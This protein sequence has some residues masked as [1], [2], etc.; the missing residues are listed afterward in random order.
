MGSKDKRSKSK[1]RKQKRRAESI[2]KEE[3]AVEQVI[4][5]EEEELPPI[6][7]ADADALAEETESAK[8]KKK[9]DKKESKK[10]KLDKES[11][12]QDADSSEKPNFYANTKDEEGKFSTLPMSDKTQ[13]GLEALKFTRMT[14]IQ[15]LAIPPLLSGKDLIGAAKTGS[16]RNEWCCDFAQMRSI[17]IR[18]TILSQYEK[19]LILFPLFNFLI[20]G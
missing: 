10:R 3:P 15:S 17:H 18:R 11:D 9:K 13:T 5:D 16:V 12:S 4:N 1:E 8:K 14:Q 6:V 20:A 2:E 19:K 7:D